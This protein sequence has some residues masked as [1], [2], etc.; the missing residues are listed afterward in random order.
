MPAPSSAVVVRD[1]QSR[2]G[3]YLT[4]SLQ[5]EIYGLDILQVREIIEYTKPTKVPMMPDFVHGV[6]N[7]RGNVV[8]VIDLTQRFG[9]QPTE[10]RKRTCIVILEVAN[11]MEQQALG[12]LVDGVNAVLDLADD[13]IE[14]SPSFGTGLPQDFILG[15]ARWEEGFI[16][17]LDVSRVLSVEDMAAI[18]ARA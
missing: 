14:P 7:L 10:I 16:I 17:L 15:M 6:I 2:G 5:G 18:S 13:Q 11:E 1:A 8:P 12:I 9:R 4:F 3:Q